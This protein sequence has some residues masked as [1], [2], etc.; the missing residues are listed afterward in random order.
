M[1][2]DEAGYEPLQGLSSSRQSSSVYTERTYLRA[3]A[4]LISPLTPILQPRSDNEPSSISP[5]GAEGFEE[6]MRWMYLSP[7]GPS[8]LS[9]AINA[10]KTILTS[11][12]DPE[13]V[14]DGLTAVSKGAALLL[15]RVV[16]KLEELEKQSSSI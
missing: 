16:V 12:E 4:F 7:F 8:L 10:C 2:I 13:Q 9:K 11:S 15:R 3:R 14:R 5:R 1:A 6:I